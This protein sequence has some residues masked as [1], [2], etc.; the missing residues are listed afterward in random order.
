MKFLK[1]NENV[2]LNGK[3][4]SVATIK[5]FFAADYTNKFTRGDKTPSEVAAEIKA[6][7][8][9]SIEIDKSVPRKTEVAWINQCS[10]C[11]CSDKS[12]YERE[13]L[14]WANAQELTDGELVMLDG[15][16]YTVKYKGNYSDMATFIPV[17]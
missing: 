13:A 14:K 9:Q 6:K 12:Y 7:I 1:H 11:I 10:A 17:A 3:K 15:E 2:I 16:F 5:G 8:E 4:G